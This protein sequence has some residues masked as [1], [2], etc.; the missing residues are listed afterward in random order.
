[1]LQIS[2]QPPNP[3]PVQDPDV[4]LKLS[5]LLPRPESD[6]FLAWECGEMVPPFDSI[7]GMKDLVGVVGSITHYLFGFQWVGYKTLWLGASSQV[8]SLPS[9]LSA[10]VSPS[11]TSGI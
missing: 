8:P 10:V 3:A 9:W 11:T 5:P 7:V 2:V 4:E 1:M 6:C